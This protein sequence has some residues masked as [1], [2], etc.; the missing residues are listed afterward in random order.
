MIEEENTVVARTKFPDIFIQM[1]CDFLSETCSVVFEK[2][3]ILNDLL[4]LDSC[5]LIS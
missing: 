2:L 1:L 3:N 4:V 5:I